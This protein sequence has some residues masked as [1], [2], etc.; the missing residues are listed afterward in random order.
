MDMCVELPMKGIKDSLNVSVCGGIM[1]YYLT[2]D[3]S[4][5][6]NSNKS[7]IQNKISKEK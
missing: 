7:K 5:N 4:I 6:K 3:K 2:S 1:L